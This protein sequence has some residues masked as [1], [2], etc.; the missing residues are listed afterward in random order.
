MQVVRPVEEAKVP[1]RH[2]VHAAWPATPLA[3]PAEHAEQT[4]L[5]ADE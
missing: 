5:A 4:V 2:D 3:V 1:A